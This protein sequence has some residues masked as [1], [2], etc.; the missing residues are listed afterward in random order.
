MHKLVTNTDHALKHPASALLMRSPSHTPWAVDCVCAEAAGPNIQEVK[1]A[2]EF[3]A[4]HKHLAGGHSKQ[5]GSMP[6]AMSTHTESGTVIPAD[7]G[8]AGTA[9]TGQL[10][11]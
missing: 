11:Q 10:L 5:T 4:I 6:V 2:E 1:T 7:T 9:G 8:T 3:E